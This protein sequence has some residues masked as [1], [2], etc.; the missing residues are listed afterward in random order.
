MLSFQADESEAGSPS[1]YACM[2]VGMRVYVHVISNN[3]HLLSA[4]I[5]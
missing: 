3:T 1:V 4:I 2:H 5:Q